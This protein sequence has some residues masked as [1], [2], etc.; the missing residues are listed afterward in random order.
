M[1]SY[2]TDSLLF[3]Q[4][5]LARTRKSPTLASRPRESNLFLNKV[6]NENRTSIFRVV[7]TF[8]PPYERTAAVNQGPLNWHIQRL[9]GGSRKLDGGL[10][11]GEKNYSRAEERGTRL[12]ASTGYWIPSLWKRDGGGVNLRSICI[13]LS[14][15]SLSHPLLSLPLLICLHSTHPAPPH[16][17]FSPASPDSPRR[18]RHFHSH[19]TRGDFL[20]VAAAFLASPLAPYSS[21]FFLLLLC[22]QPSGK[23]WI[24][25]QS[26]LL[27]LI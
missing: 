4:L 11:V 15:S 1:W 9:D 17:S 13:P 22:G 27:V 5:K 12:R 3:I 7:R 8:I 24:V 14:C 20:S 10:E 18:P 19:F 16:P 21:L 23:R 25:S 6:A 2:L 26:Y